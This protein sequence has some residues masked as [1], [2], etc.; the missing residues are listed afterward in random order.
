M[1]NIKDFRFKLIIVYIQYSAY[2]A[3]VFMQFKQKNKEVINF[4][5][6]DI[7]N[8]F[9]SSHKSWRPFSN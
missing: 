8:V 4:L 6:N 3:Y 7:N 5:S 1:N 2:F 9:H